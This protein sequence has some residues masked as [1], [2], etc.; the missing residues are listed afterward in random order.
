MMVIRKEG[1]KMPEEKNRSCVDEFDNVRITDA[2]GEFVAGGRVIATKTNDD[3]KDV[4]VIDFGLK[5]KTE[6]LTELLKGEMG[7]G[8]LRQIISDAFLSLVVQ[9]R[10]YGIDKFDQQMFEGHPKRPMARG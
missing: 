8:L 5:G 3:G 10:G 2:D 4:S 7:N 1:E 6:L 9:I